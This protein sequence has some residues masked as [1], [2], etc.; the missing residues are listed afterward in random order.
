[1]TSLTW[2]TPLIRGLSEIRL[3]FS[4]HVSVTAAGCC[5]RLR[6]WK[7][8][9]ATTN[10]KSY[11]VASRQQNSQSVS[12]LCWKKS[13][14]APV[15]SISPGLSPHALAT[16]LTMS[17]AVWFWNVRLCRWRFRRQPRS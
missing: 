5:V 8:W 1:M 4:P 9:S 13:W 17:S 12:M 7:S 10:S 3:A 6:K 14:T 15:L 11:I 2:P 16:V